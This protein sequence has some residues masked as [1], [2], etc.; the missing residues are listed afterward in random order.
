[1]GQQVGQREHHDHDGDVDVD[2]GVVERRQL[3]EQ[4]VVFAF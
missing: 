2:P 1:V 4:R 3:R